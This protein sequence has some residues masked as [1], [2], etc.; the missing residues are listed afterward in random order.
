MKMTGIT[1][2]VAE[3]EKINVSDKKKSRGKADE[4]ERESTDG[5]GQHWSMED[6]SGEAI[7]AGNNMGKLMRKWGIRAFRG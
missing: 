7:A 4:R 6:G 2:C 1:R 3:L 5:Q